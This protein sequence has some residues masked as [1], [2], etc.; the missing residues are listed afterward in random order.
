MIK[1]KSRELT[2]FEKS[3]LGSNEKIQFS[4]KVSKPDLIPKIIKNLK[5][6]ILGFHL[7]LEDTNYVYQNNPI[8]LHPIPN[9]IKT[10]RDACEYVSSIN[11]DYTDTLSVISANDNIVAI[12]VSH[13]VCD[14]GFFVDIFD[15]LLLNDQYPMKSIFPLTTSHVLQHELNKVTKSEIRDY[16]SVH[17]LTSLKWSKNFKKLKKK[18][19]KKH[20]M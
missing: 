5:H 3:F 14:G 13:M 1:V 9:N 4:V 15:K 11:Y 6:Y 19:Y 8:T 12:S 16:Q 20:I 10:A 17:N 7:K 18:C 2:S